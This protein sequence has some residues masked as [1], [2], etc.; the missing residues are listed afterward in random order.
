MTNMSRLITTLT[1]TLLL[2]SAA[3]AVPTVSV[4]YTGFANGSKTGDIYG[5]RNVGVNAGQF[6]FNVTSGSYWDDEL[7]GFC[8][9]V[10]QNLVTS[11]QA[12][13]K[14]VHFG[15]SSTVNSQQM[16]LISQL[17][18]NRAGNLGS[19]LNDA[20]FQLSLWEIVYD[21]SGTLGLTAGGSQNFWASSFDGARTLANSWLSELQ[22]GI[23]YTSSQY[24]FYT[25]EP[26]SP[27]KNQRLLVARPSVKVSEP[28]SL[29]LLAIGMLGILVVQRRL[30]TGTQAAARN[31]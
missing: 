21:Y 6:T 7:R 15:D 9:D 29:A 27:V 19:A 20:A 12:T 2:S 14:L 16:S 5:E 26:E 22:T 8:I 23:D 30:A 28:G 11:G 3:Q 18:D 13:Y 4:Q 1:A 25:L 24:D 17:Y 31:G 10:N